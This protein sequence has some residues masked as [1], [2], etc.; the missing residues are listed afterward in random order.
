MTRGVSPL[1]K[2]LKQVC[3]EWNPEKGGGGK[4]R[5]HNGGNISIFLLRVLRSSEGF[6]AAGN[7]T[8][9]MFL[10]EW[11]FCHVEKDLGRGKSGEEEQTVQRPL[12]APKVDGMV[13]VKVT[14]QWRQVGNSN[15][16]LSD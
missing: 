7:R 4:A 15:R 12:Q 3:R 8:R 2:E 6:Q 1:F 10:Q 5:L 16:H 9:F 13:I 14:G 11:S